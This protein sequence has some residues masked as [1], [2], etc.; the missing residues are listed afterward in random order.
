MH[1]GPS[2]R[3][4]TLALSFLLNVILVGL[5]V[6]ASHQEFQ[7]EISVS[8]S[9]TAVPAEPAT[10]QQ[11]Y[12]AYYQALLS[13]GLSDVEARTLLLV[14]LE[15]EARTRVG[16][17]APKY[18]QAPA[19][20]G[21]DVGLR[22]LDELDRVRRVLSGIFGS[23]A[24]LDPT[25][26]KVFRPLDPEFSFLTSTQ[27]IE[28]QRLKLKRQQA[29]IEAAQNARSRGNCQPQVQTADSAGRPSDP[30]GFVVE[31]AK[32][33]KEPALSEYLLRD[34]SLAAQ[35][36]ASRVEF[37]EPEFRETFHILRRLEESPASAGVYAEARDALRRVLGDRRFA[38]FWAT[39]DP[40]FAAI[41][42]T[43]E[44]HSMTEDTLASVYEIFADY[45]DA[46]TNTL[47]SGP[48]DPER[49]RRELGAARTRMKGRLSGLVGEET[50]DDFLRSYAQ[51]MANVGRAVPQRA[52]RLPD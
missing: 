52:M 32:V 50:A 40:F 34:S 14:R 10:V 18:W 47:R 42:R 24:E 5:V 37:T 30:T 3:R 35:L 2:V 36:R 8:P 38:Q 46:M 31:L 19:T 23:Q 20:A 41:E 1:I 33:L 48:P 29:S 28:I 9:H 21:I 11:G 25:L 13:R 16:P 6:R 22:L 26:A 17:S 27:Q 39:R 51:E 4:A 7:S 43:A 49:A 44:R 15:G 12:P 45:Q